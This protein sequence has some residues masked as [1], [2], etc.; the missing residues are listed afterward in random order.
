MVSVAS[1]K[2]PI[3]TLAL[4]ALLFLKAVESLV[5]RMP[6]KSGLAHSQFTQTSVPITCRGDHG[7]QDERKS[8]TTRA[9]R[10]TRTITPPTTTAIGTSPATGDR[11]IPLETSTAEA[12][13]SP[14]ESWCVSHL[15]RLYNRALSIRCPFW[16][17]RA[18]DALD[19]MD[20]I[21]RF[22]V[23]RHK[24]IPLIS[25]PAGWK[26]DSLAKNKHLSTLEL[27][28][29]IYHDWQVDT[30]RGYYIT[31]R[32]NTTVYRDDC[33]FDGPDP[34]M[35]V[36]GLRKYLNAASQLFDPTKSRAELLSLQIVVNNQGNTHPACHNFH[37]ILVDA[38]SN[39]S[40]KATWRMRGVLRLPWKPTLP[41]WTGTT[42]YHRDG[43]GLIYQHVE[44]WDM[45][46]VQ[47]FVKTFW[48]DI[49]K[50]LWTSNH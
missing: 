50:V 8:I 27:W 36:R 4:R 26:L 39:D 44:T 46:M 18:S 29:V 14:L 41:E 15:D 11:G 20:Q 21:M 40:I 30:Q 13:L 33:L 43:E 2:A 19:A 35:P 12:V 9:T 32:L 42:T 6:M 23:I 45:S 16:K 48:P 1:W 17:R 34:D 5:P 38:N 28:N 31:G 47:A 49:S 22:V 37:N 24:S 3:L 25:P 10:R 7:S